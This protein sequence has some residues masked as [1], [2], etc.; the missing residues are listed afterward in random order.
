M[1]TEKMT[2]FLHFA[3]QFFRNNFPPQGVWFTVG[4]N[5]LYSHQSNEFKI[6]KTDTRKKGKNLDT[7]YATSLS[8]PCITIVR[9]H[10]GGSM[11]LN[12][13]ILLLAYMVYL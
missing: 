4:K 10:C 3:S 7:A 12:A 8:L 6:R 5:E 13:H 1:I 11:E 2:T 9:Y